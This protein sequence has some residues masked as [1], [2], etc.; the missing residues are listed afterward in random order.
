V[1]HHT[2]TGTAFVS[3]A[4]GHVLDLPLSPLY[5]G[6]VSIQLLLMALIH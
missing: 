3:H 4:V 5:Q 2:Y 6:L 1:S